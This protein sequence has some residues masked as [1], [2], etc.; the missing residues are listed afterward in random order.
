MPVHELAK[1]ALELWSYRAA[2][3]E[4]IDLINREITGLMNEFTV[5]CAA[6]ASS[7]AGAGAGA[8][9]GADGGSGDSTR[10]PTLMEL[11]NELGKTP[12]SQGK[13]L[14]NA[15]PDLFAAEVTIAMNKTL[16]G[17]SLQGALDSPG[18][19]LL[20]KDERARLRT[21]YFAYETRYVELVTKY[22]LP[23]EEIEELVKLAATCATRLR[24]H[25]VK[26]WQEVQKEIP[27]LLAAVFAAWSVHG[28]R[29]NYAAAG[30]NIDAVRMPSVIQVGKYRNLSEVSVLCRV[31]FVNVVF[32]L[33][34]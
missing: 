2:D 24:A 32:T 10:L 15:F 4:I 30:N 31:L 18:L 34:A 8:D 12:D 1:K 7:S 26:A 22:L 11:G 14:V 16:R 13:A 28:S 3:R 27:V 23:S 33:F 20:S 17:V 5:S 19:Q 29:T 6:P 9:G 21:A 25:G